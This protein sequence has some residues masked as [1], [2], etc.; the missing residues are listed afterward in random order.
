MINLDIMYRRDLLLK[1]LDDF[2]EAIARIMGKIERNELPSADDEI[3]SLLSEEAVRQLTE[4][5]PLPPA[6]NY[7]Y[8]KFQTELLLL[9]WKISRANKIDN[10]LQKERCLRAIQR[11]MALRPGTY[12]LGLSEALEELG[13]KV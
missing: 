3:S 7:D 9:Q 1:Q 13:S 5:G 4:E 11:L 2:F 10:S 6:A 8:L 12:D